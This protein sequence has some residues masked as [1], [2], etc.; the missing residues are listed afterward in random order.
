M[1]M[2]AFWDITQSSLPAVTDVSEE[3]TTSIIRTI[4]LMKEAVRTFETSVYFNESTRRY[5]P[6]TCHLQHVPILFL[7]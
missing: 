3:H 1:K 4:T 7:Q 2:A 6:K 5:I